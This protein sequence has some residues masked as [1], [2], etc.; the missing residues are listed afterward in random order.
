MSNCSFEDVDNL[1]K[2]LQLVI[3]I[4]IFIFGLILNTLALLVFCLLLK[5]WTESTIYMTNLVLMDMLLLF[6]MPFK[7]HATKYHWAADKRLFCSFLE[8][9]YFVSVYGSIYTIMCIAVDRYIAIKHPF[10]AKQLRSPRAALVT[11][12]VIWLVVLGATAPVYRFHSKSEE[13]FRCF[14]GFSKEGWNP[15][16][17]VCLEVLGFLGPTLVLVSCSVQIIRTLRKSLQ[18]S[19]QSRACVRIIYSNLCIFLVPFTPCHVG[20]F[21]Q[22][23]VRCGTITDCGLQNRISLFV[24]VSMGLANITCCLDAFCYYFITM[25]IRSSRGSLRQSFSQRRMTS[26]SEV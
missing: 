26:T 7:M 24:Q 3:Y 19:A 13:P 18:S 6:P 23:L 25:E 8:S 9:L 16:L 20:I 21:L 22:F 15:V 11:C 1:M 4:P 17:I 10:R 12:V 5:K 14:H 2:S